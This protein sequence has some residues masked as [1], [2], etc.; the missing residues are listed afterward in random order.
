[1]SVSN[2]S[3][4]W[5]CKLCKK[6]RFGI[7]IMLKSPGCC[8]PVTSLSVHHFHWGT[9]HALLGWFLWTQ[10]CLKYLRP[11]FLEPCSSSNRTEAKRLVPPWHHTRG[12]HEIGCFRLALPWHHACGTHTI[13]CFR[14]MATKS[15]VTANQCSCKLTQMMPEIGREQGQTKQSPVTCIPE[16]YS[17]H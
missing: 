3:W 14:V 15:P 5:P 17:L 12:T 1:M 10:K 2:R 16:Q 6:S 4:T 11:P 7:Y 8:R 9:E 13:G